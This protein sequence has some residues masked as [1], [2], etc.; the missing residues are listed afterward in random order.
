MLLALLLGIIPQADATTD[1]V[2]EIEVNRFYDGDG[3]LILTQLIFRDDWRRIIDWRLAKA[4]PRGN[5]V[6]WID[7]DQ[8][9]SVTADKVT[10][11]W[12]Q[13]DPELEERAILPKEFRAGLF[14]RPPR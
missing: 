9:Y 10:E 3:R 5:R 8:M 7:C 14:G 12:S 1:H 13:E 6:T 2:A 4:L 11:S